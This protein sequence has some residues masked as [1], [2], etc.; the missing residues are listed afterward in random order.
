MLAFGVTTVEAKSG[1]GLDFASEKQLEVGKALNKE[2]GPLVVN[3]FMGAHAFPK[4]C[5]HRDTYLSNLLK[6][7]EVFRKE[8]L[9]EFV[10]VFC[11]EGVFSLAETKLILERAQ[12]LGYGLKMHADEMVSL[13]G[14]A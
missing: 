5:E 10:D 13:G 14:R 8:E 1:Y 6:W 7:M 3:T 2:L 9:A 4:T 11:E 12:A